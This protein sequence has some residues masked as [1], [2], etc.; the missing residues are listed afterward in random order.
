MT[1]NLKARTYE[2][3]WMLALAAGMLTAVAG[4]PA[5]LV[6]EPSPPTPVRTSASFQGPIAVEFPPSSAAQRI[7]SSSGT[8]RVTIDQDDQGGVRLR[9]YEG[10]LPGFTQFGTVV[11]DVDLEAGAVSGEIIMPDAGPLD[12][13]IMFPELS[14]VAHSS[15]HGFDVSAAGGIHRHEYTLALPDLPSSLDEATLAAGLD[16]AVQV[17]HRRHTDGELV[18]DDQGTGTIQASRFEGEQAERDLPLPPRP[19]VVDA[20]FD[21]QIQVGQAA[22]LMPSVSGGIAPLRYSWSPALDLDNPTAEGPLASPSTTTTYTLTVVDEIG[23]QALDSVKV[24]VETGD[25]VAENSND[26]VVDESEDAND[27]ILDENDNVVDENGNDNMVDHEDEHED[28]ASSYLEEV[29]FISIDGLGAKPALSIDGNILYIA[30]AT[31]VY[32]HDITD[33]AWPVLLALRTSGWENLPDFEYH[34]ADGHLVNPTN[35]D[36]SRMNWCVKTMDGLIVWAGNWDMAVFPPAINNDFGAP[37]QPWD[38]PTHIVRAQGRL[39]SIKETAVGSVIQRWEEPALYWDEG[40]DHWRF[41]EP[42]FEAEGN[43]KC[44]FYSRLAH[45]QGFLASGECVFELH[46]ENGQVQYRGKLNG[47]NTTITDISISSGLLWRTDFDTL[48]VYEVPVSGPPLLIDALERGHTTINDVEAMGYW[49]VFADGSLQH[50][51]QIYGLDDS[52]QLRLLEEIDLANPV[53]RLLRHGEHLYAAGDAGLTVFRALPGTVDDQGADHD[54]EQHHGDVVEDEG[55]LAVFGTV[56]DEITGDPVPGITVWLNSSPD[57][58]SEEATTDAAG[59]VAFEVP[60]TSRFKFVTWDPNGIYWG[61]STWVYPEAGDTSIQV[62]LALE[63]QPDPCDDGNQCTHDELVNGQC[64]HTLV[65][66][67]TQVCDPVSGSC[68]ACLDAGD[69][70]AGETCE[71]STCVSAG[72]NTVPQF[73][74]ASATGG[75]TAG[76]SATVTVGCTVTDSDGFVATVAVDLSSIGGNLVQE[77]SHT[78]GDQWEWSGPV[79]PLSTGEQAI[80]FAAVDNDGGIATAQATIIVASG[81]GPTGEVITLDLGGAYM[82]LVRLSAATFTMGSNDGQSDEAPVHQ[83]TLSEDFYIGRYEVTQAQYQ[84]VMGEN[85][86]HFAGCLQCPVENVSWGEAVAFCAAVSSRTGYDIRLPT[87]AEWEYA[88]RAG[89]DSDYFFGDDSY[90]LT[91][92]AWMVTNTDWTHPVGTRLPNPWQLYDMYGNVSEWCSDWYGA[93]Y[94]AASPLTD[95]AGPASGTKRVTRGGW[96]DSIPSSCRSA[97]RMGTWTYGSWAKGFR[98][99]ADVP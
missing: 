16:C 59:T 87:E 63:R 50:D 4:C 67:G 83:V 53:G 27:N 1:R 17:A 62:T 89:T 95:P 35:G 90:A 39:Y 82:P 7:S 45:G 94:Y 18:I 85:P 84:A 99:A 12:L 11:A 48:E 26:N 41:R 76:I 44:D 79:A 5:P 2:R 88:C 21:Q 81:G 73:G 43:C 42:I 96:F 98:C 77:L 6:D 64:A 34:H 93:D 36:K 58:E 57:F 40:P 97:S 55:L 66:C 23:Q 28:E 19:I 61:R 22:A 33:P 86:S 51:L 60:L 92:Y 69:C 13:R 72:T 78:S 37:Y 15:G 24:F 20:G 14:A 8:V 32:A 68:V 49:A 71:N 31:G 25:L 47:T 3:H 80:T 30:G 46:H 54:D 38:L 70:A 91:E 29:A 9:R 74:D 10:V 52:L 56:V 65:D 75:L